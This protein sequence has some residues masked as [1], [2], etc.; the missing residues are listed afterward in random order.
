MSTPSLPQPAAPSR[1][2]MAS[3]IEVLEAGL[4]ERDA[5]ARL[6]LLAAVA[7]EHVLL[8]GPP[9]TA[10]SELARRLQMIIEAPAEGSGATVC[11][12]RLLTRFSTPEELFG[13]LSLKALEDD[14]YER[15]VE[16][17]L[18]TAQVAFL[19]EV[20]KA[21]S[22]ILNALL[23]LLNERVFDN[24]TQ[25]LPVPLVTVVGASNET[26][27]DEALQAFHDRFL[28]RVPV[29]PVGDAS[30]EAL[31]A[32]DLARPPLRSAAHTAANESRR[33]GRLN[34]A[35]RQAVEDAAASVVLTPDTLQALHALRTLLKAGNVVVSDR[36]WRALARL[37]RVA[38]AAEGRSLVE[39][40]DLW[41]A[42]YVTAPNPQALDQVMRWWQQDV[43]RVGPADAPGWRHSAQ[44]FEK[45][46]EIETQ[47]L[48]EDGAES[49]GKM[50]LARSLGGAE[51]TGGNSEMLRLYSE[52]V[53]ARL[54]RRWSPLHIRA[55]VAQ[56]Q[57]LRESVQ[58]AHTQAQAEW[59]QLQGTLLGRL[60]LP[61]SWAHNTLAPL[62][63]RVALLEA[64][65]QRLQATEQGF[66]ALPVN[67]DLADV[68]A[69]MTVAS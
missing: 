26:P 18:P 63:E 13:P 69:P 58:A 28:L 66:A 41:L 61:P 59:A 3:M 27:E 19:D 54:R 43:L 17:Y 64:L 60:W 15:L 35:S 47:A 29:Q 2:A 25:R 6:V 20:F 67:E 50:A 16:G 51:G 9:G 55:R 65:V 42:S 36:R 4:L 32:S 68:P 22:A 23:T 45:Q 12:E 48:A 7:G 46:L 56:V 44:A 40:Y 37:L 21:N 38:A 14:R 5:A 8:L 33:A 11:F 30:F 49:A 39:P 62:G 52:R 10:K 24:G 57:D 53:E 34:A 31:V 1:A